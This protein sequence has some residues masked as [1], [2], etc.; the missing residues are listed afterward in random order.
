MD[1]EVEAPRRR[2]TGF[3]GTAGFA[4]L[5]LPPGATRGRQNATRSAR[6]A[7]PGSGAQVVVVLALGAGVAYAATQ[8][9]STDGT[10][11]CVNQTNGLM[12]AS[13]TCREGEYAMT[14]GG[15]SDVV[16]TPSGRVTVALGAAS[17]PMTLPL[18]GLTVQGTCER[19]NAPSRPTRPMRPWR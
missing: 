11:V 19:V 5:V 10:Q 1:T 7:Q 13:S 9:A 15:G 18:T 8:L 6:S 16:A 12:R 17:A 14:I 4:H 3:T 2:P